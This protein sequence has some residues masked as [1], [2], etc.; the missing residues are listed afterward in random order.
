MHLTQRGRTH[1]HCTSLIHNQYAMTAEECF[2][3]CQPP[4]KRPY[5]LIGKCGANSR[6]E[7]LKMKEK[8]N[9]KFRFIQHLNNLEGDI[10]IIVILPVTYKQPPVRVVFHI[11]EDLQCVTLSFL[12]VSLKSSM[13]RTINWIIQRTQSYL[14]VNKS[15]IPQ[16][17]SVDNY[18]GECNDGNE[19]DQQHSMRSFKIKQFRTSKSWLLDIEIECK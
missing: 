9:G 16:D 18:C 8:Q 2:I 17:R 7:Y 14:L 13:M 1:F 15:A 12:Q 5:V 11:V 10:A 6:W 4:Y 3:R 19:L